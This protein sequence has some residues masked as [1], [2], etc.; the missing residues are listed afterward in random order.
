MTP[1]A[2]SQRNLPA[3][4]GPNIRPIRPGRCGWLCR[5]ESGRS[6]RRRAPSGSEGSGSIVIVVRS[7]MR[8]GAARLPAL[9]G[10]A[11]PRARS[12][13]VA[14]VAVACR[15]SISGSPVPRRALH[16]CPC[17]RER[18][19]G[20]MEMP[21]GNGSEGCG[22]GQCGEGLVQGPRPR[23]GGGTRMSAGVGMATPGR[24]RWRLPDRSAVVSGPVVG[25][26]AW[27]G[28]FG[29]SPVEVR[30]RGI[31]R[32]ASGLGAFV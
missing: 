5:S 23:Q 15:I 20:A 18:R 13:A 27:R 17:R 19:S 3:G 11:S 25:R 12:S 8:R 24:C 26:E 31:R 9:M 32:S 10:P 2:L 29:A 1:Q 4:S 21:T 28:F 16:Q 30:R 14:R 6:G 22:D 7:G